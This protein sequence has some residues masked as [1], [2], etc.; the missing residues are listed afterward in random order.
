VGEQLEDWI[1]RDDPCGSR[2]TDGERIDRVDDDGKVYQMDDETDY[3]RN[4]KF[5][6][7]TDC[8]ITLTL[9]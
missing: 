9:R 5:R 3:L 7:I 8:A 4:S 6:A 2:A 1:E